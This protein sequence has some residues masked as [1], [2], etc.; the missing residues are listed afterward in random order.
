MSTAVA[1]ITREDAV[2]ILYDRILH[3]CNRVMHQCRNYSIA[4]LKLEDPSLAKI[5]QQMRQ[6]A[7]IIRIIAPD[8]DPLVSQKAGDYC[9]L[10]TKIAIAVENEDE[11]RLSQLVTELERKPGL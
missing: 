2:A 8:N 3:V 1:Q 7:N 5:A 9:D 4:M 11:V 6:M 10:L